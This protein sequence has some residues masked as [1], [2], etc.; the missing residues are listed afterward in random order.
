MDAET[1]CYAELEARVADRLAAT[2]ADWSEAEFSALAREVFAFQRPHN[3]PYARYCESTGVG[4]EIG[5]WREIPA[6]PQAA[7]KLCALRAGFDAAGTARTFRTSGTTGEGFGQHH[8]KTLRLYEAAILGGWQHFLLPTGR[9]QIVLAP[10]PDDASHSSLAHMLGT[11]ARVAPAGEQHW[12]VSADGK[13][14]VEWVLALAGRYREAG[15]P[16]LL[17]GTALAFLHLCEALEKRGTP[18]TFPTGTEAMETGGYKGSGR[19]LTKRELYAR[20][21]RWLG[22]PAEAIFNEYGMTELSSQWY[23]RGLAQ[24]H[25]GPPW[26]RALVIDPETGREAAAGAVGVLRLFDLANLGSVLAL[27]TQDLA[28]AH[29][30]GTFTLL[31]RDPQ[32][33]PRGC[34]R[35]ADE[36]LA[37]TA[38]TSPT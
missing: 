33:L 27:G 11:L 29:G 28:E 5:D 36:L 15:R 25:A 21:E 20:F 2:A 12:C 38:A 8:F 18:V 24:P 32:A 26:T 31:G 4:L 35:A 1:R 7:F 37:A 13:L 22:L 10:H 9:P 3:A 17:L 30:D 23:A 34:S 6:M 16:V 19:T 14:E